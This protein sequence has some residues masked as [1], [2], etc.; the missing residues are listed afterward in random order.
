MF[1]ALLLL[2]Y[3]MQIIIVKND[4]KTTIS[5]VGRLALLLSRPKNACYGR[6]YDSLHLQKTKKWGIMVGVDGWLFFT[7]IQLAKGECIYAK[8]EKDKLSLL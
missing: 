1:Y 8:N 6:K 7:E 3:K 4:E 5:T 2:N